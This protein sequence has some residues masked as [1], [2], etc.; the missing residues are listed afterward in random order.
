MKTC[1][2]LLLL[3]TSVHGFGAITFTSRPPTALFRAITEQDA[4]FLL[5]KARECAYSDSCKV[6]DAKHYLRELMHIQSGCIVGTLAGRELCESQDQ[7]AD[8]VQLLQAKVQS[9]E[10]E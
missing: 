6:D 8:I 2:F 10:K 5:A 7:A 1:A 9:D 3:L 4:K